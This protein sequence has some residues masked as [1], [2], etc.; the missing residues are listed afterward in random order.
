MPSARSD[1]NATIRRLIAEISASERSG[2]FERAVQGYRQ[3]LR[4]K[5]DFPQAWNNLGA[6]LKDLGQ[7]DEAGDAYRQ[8]MVFRPDYADALS[9]LGEVLER[10]GRADDALINFVRAIALEP[11]AA[12]VQSNLGN[13]LDALARHD[14]AG[15]VFRRAIAL[16][17]D[18]AKAHFNL[19]HSLS[20]RSSHGDAVGSLQRAVALDP[21]HHEAQAE[22]GVALAALD[23]ADEAIAAWRRA[24]FFR[25]ESSDLHA[26]LGTALLHHGKPAEALDALRRAVAG[27]PD[28]A[29]AYCNVGLALKDLQRTADAIVAWR[30][31]ARLNAE[32]AK[33]HTNIGI[34]LTLAGDAAEGR[35]AHRRAIILD[36]AFAAAYCSLG[37][38]LK[39]LDRTRDAVTAWQRA[40]QV[41]R[42]MAV[43]YS[44]IGVALVHA[45]QLEAGKAAHRRAIALTPGL[46]DAY[47]GLGLALVEYCRLDEA[48]RLFRRADGLDPGQALFNSN[49]LFCL[50]YHPDLE[51]EAIFAEYRRWDEQP[52]RP[53]LPPE[54]RYGNDRSPG[55]RIRVGYV[56]PDFRRHSARH[57]IEPLLAHHDRRQVE[58]VAYANHAVDDEVTARCRGHVDHWRRT[59]GLT[60]EAMADLIR[61]DA[62]DILV[63]LAGHTRDNRLSVFARRPAPVQV[64]SWLGYGYTTGLSAMDYF[65]GDAVFTP[66][67]CEGVFAEQ[68]VRLPVFTAYRP[69]EGM[70][71][72]GPLP[73]ISRGHITFGTL[74][75]MVRINHR[76]VRAWA[77]ILRQLPAARLVINCSSLR[78]PSLRW[79]L[80][81]RFVDHGIGMD[82]LILGYDSPPWD[83]LRRIDICLDGFPHNSGTTLC[84]SLYMGLPV[85]TL[86]SRPSVGRMCAALLSA[87][88]HA[89]WIAADE[90]AY[91]GTAVRLAGDMP[92][93]AA[94]RAALRGQMQASR[95]MDEAGYVHSVEAAYRRMWRTWCGAP[96]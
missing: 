4:L 47:N 45:G 39:D 22:L 70:G 21:R 27:K 55:R 32:M 52:A 33:P 46:A 13:T 23:R 73:A 61:A 59:I 19:G 6:A 90:E 69:A 51:A 50:N 11:E 81:A 48:I 54:I 44:N 71:E 8:A 95:L 78:C 26:D 34:V 85:V 31:A 28:Y 79:D 20:R 91:V 56:S 16:R 12:A 58:L 38:A 37:L 96:Q 89:E 64:A 83:V 82:Q 74:T 67:G 63:D 29:Q 25:P 7:T 57:F 41:D 35:D 53:R 92:R 36:P 87:I 43:A 77:A 76:V 86:A 88:G 62:I 93:L 9:N 15:I 18:Y 42:H 72:A 80:I 5:P 2:A 75:R 84:E 40:V 30:Q 3:I 1:R 94:L 66:P 68:V 14:E 60:D 17:P 24:L 49:I 10:S 65:L